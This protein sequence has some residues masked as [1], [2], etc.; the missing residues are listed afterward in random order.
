MSDYVIYTDSACDLDKSIL[1]KWG[2]KCVELKFSFDGENKSYGNYE[3]ASKD[4]YNRMREGGSAKTSAVNV[5]EFKE[6]FITTLKEDKDILY[7]GFSS[8]LSMTFNSAKIAADDLTAEYPQR[9]IIA[10][11][12]LCAS[13]GQ[14]LLVYLCKKK[15]KEGLSLEAVADYARDLIPHLCH[16]FTVDDLTYLKRGGRISP[17]VAF[18]GGVLGVKPVLHVD[19]E[20]K[21]VNVTKTRGRA[22]ALQT[23]VDK[24]EQYCPDPQNSIVF[25]SHS[26]CLEDAQKVDD[27]IYKKFGVKAKSISYI[28]PVIGAHTGPGTIAFF[29]VGKQR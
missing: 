12:S 1:D 22:N 24:F 8:G 17:T 29:F 2:V 25:M 6:S 19:D 3:M 26:D 18:V 10:I 7:I 13:A 23:I 9:K 15:K 21:L 11:D 27:M 4:F 20:G 14:G 5:E 28:G 16:W